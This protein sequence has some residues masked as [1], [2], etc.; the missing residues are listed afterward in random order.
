MFLCEFLYLSN[1]RSYGLAKISEEKFKKK[2]TKSRHFDRVFGTWNFLCIWYMW[3]KSQ[4]NRIKI[5]NSRIQV[6][7]STLSPHRWWQWTWIFKLSHSPSFWRVIYKFV[8]F[9]FD[10]IK[11]SYILFNPRGCNSLA[12]NF[13]RALLQVKLYGTQ[14]I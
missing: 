2:L 6:R 14:E 4:L 9:Q 11:I 7:F 5:T 3:P 12:W 1:L 8:K 10:R 13:R